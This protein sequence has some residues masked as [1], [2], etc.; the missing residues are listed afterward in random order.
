MD[1]RSLSNQEISDLTWAES[2]P[3]IAQKNTMKKVNFEELESLK[4]SQE[5][6]LVKFSGV[7]CP[8]CIRMTD[9]LNQVAPN[10]PQMTVIEAD[11]LENLEE[12]MAF[13]LGRA[14]P[15]TFLY[16]KGV[17]VNIEKPFHLVGLKSTEDVDKVLSHFI[18]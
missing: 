9:I 14:V 5:W 15:Q 17:A 10:Y 4:K 12:V 16:H 6:L 18:Q 7:S 8:P 13:G 3:N 2:T 11:A 1:R